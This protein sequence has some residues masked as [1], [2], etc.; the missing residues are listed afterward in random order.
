MWTQR[1][2]PA[3]ESIQTWSTWQGLSFTTE[4]RVFTQACAGLR[5]ARESAILRRQ[6]HSGGSNL[7]SETVGQP[8]MFTPFRGRFHDMSP[9]GE[10]YWWTESEAQALYAQRL[11]V[12]LQVKNSVGDINS[13]VIQ[14]NL[15]LFVLAISVNG[16]AK[17]AWVAG[18]QTDS[19]HPACQDQ[20]EWHQG[21]TFKDISRL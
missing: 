16:S 4:F 8:M 3:G 9:L 19:D 21:E 13:S 17:C 10:V 6:H 14:S 18:P 2:Q 11:G 5:E 1:R 7:R 15:K 20:C 12:Q